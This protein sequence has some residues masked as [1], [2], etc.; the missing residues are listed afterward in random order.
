MLNIEIVASNK[1]FTQNSF[2]TYNG[3]LIACNI[4]FENIMC[5]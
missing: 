2:F 4:C 1:D 5:V 3:E